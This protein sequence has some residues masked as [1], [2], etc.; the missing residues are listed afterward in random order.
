MIAKGRDTSV[1]CRMYCDST[2]LRGSDVDGLIRYAK[3]DRRTHTA[4]APRT[5]AV[6][7]RPDIH[8]P[9]RAVAIKSQPA[10]HDGLGNATTTGGT[11]RYSYL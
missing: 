4:E 5:R 3:P 11:V 2:N 1:L 6:P 10:N 8:Q 7:Y 9:P